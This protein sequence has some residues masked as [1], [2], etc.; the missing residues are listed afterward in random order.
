[1]KASMRHTRRKP[2]PGFTLIEIL[3]VLIIIGVLFAISAPSWTALMNRQR[4][5]TVREQAVQ[6]IREAQNKARLTR[7]PQAIVFDNNNNDGTIAPRAAIVA[8]SLNLTTDKIDKSIINI[9]T[10]NNW[11]T[12]G[13]GDVKG[14][15]IDFFAGVG[16]LVFDGNGAIDEQTTIPFVVKVKPRNA[17]AQTYRCAVVQTLLGSIRLTDGEKD[18]TLCK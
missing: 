12:L 13:G 9:A 10:I 18:T 2:S 6:V 7:V 1:M 5:G 11:Q 4:V 8:R 17:S 3:V 15:G 16:Q 14:G